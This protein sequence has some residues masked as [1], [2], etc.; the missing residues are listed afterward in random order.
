[1]KVPQSIGDI[2]DAN[3]E[4]FE[5]LGQAVE[6]RLRGQLDREWH[7]VGRVKDRESFALKVETGRVS[8]PANM[9]DFYACTIVVRNAGEIP[10]AEKIVLGLFDKRERRPPRPDYTYAAPSD[11]DFD[12]V[13]LYVMWRDDDTLPPTDFAG[14]PFEV[15]IK[16]Y[17]QHAWSIATHDLVYKTDEVNWRKARIA[18]QVK[19]ML[20]HAEA[21]IAHAEQLA[22]MTDLQISN[23]RIDEVRTVIAVL[24]CAWRDDPGRLPADIRRLAE[25]IL[26]LLREAN[27]KPDDL[28]SD[29]TAEE[30]A[31]RGVLIETLSPFGIV[32]QTL[33]NRR[34]AVMQSVMAKPPGRR[35]FRVVIPAEIAV[36]PGIDLTTCPNA[37]VLSG[38]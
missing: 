22:A 7:F 21:S 33:L 6:G 17:L 26:A 4:R 38:G 29:L 24:K 20:D 10:T 8:D 15:Q 3:W 25:N 30:A 35:R 34:T 27:L 19:A 14:S 5:R 23:D 16:T 12:H 18:F 31:G 1:M 36:P 2:Y 37:S 32:V 13:R 11:F 28:A 9:E